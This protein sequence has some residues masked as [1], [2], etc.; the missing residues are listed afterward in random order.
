MN[1]ENAIEKFKKYVENF[2]MKNPKV[3]HK[4]NHTFRVTEL[5]KLIAKSLSLSDEDIYIAEL[6]GLLHDIGRF[7][8]VTKYDTY[9]DRLSIDHATLGA[10][11]LFENNYINEY[12]SDK[13]IQKII[14][15]V[16]EN[17]SRYEIESHLDDRTKMFCQII[18][19]ADKIDIFK[20]VSEGYGVRTNNGKISKE[21][22]DLIVQ[23][24]QVDY[25]VIK[26]SIDKLILIIA[27]IFDINYNFSYSYLKDKKYMEKIIEKACIEYP[28]YLKE[29]IYIKYIVNK[30]L[31]IKEGYNVR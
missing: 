6:G 2:D 30:H 18:R 24:K 4:Y 8:Q 9:D 17:H 14:I 10:R 20:Q 28:N 12:I 1:I 13:E 3:K 23:Q 27:L 19:D 11:I 16:V 29:L 5:S 7:E 15:K 21:V 26:S 22:L 25:N 31:K